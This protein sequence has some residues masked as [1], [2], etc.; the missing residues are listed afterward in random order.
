[1]GKESPDDLNLDSGGEKL[2]V[3]II[4]S[5]SMKKLSFLWVAVLHGKGLSIN[6]RILRSVSVDATA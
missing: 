4:I 6:T 2:A 3:L 1:V 5:K